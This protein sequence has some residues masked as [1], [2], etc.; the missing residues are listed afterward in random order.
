ME[1]GP[2]DI[3][4]D[5]FELAPTIDQLR[6]KFS[7]FHRLVL[8]VN[9]SLE[10]LSLQHGKARDYYVSHMPQNVR[11]LLNV[12]P[13]IPMPDTQSYVE[14]FD[15]LL[16]IS[17]AS[18]LSDDASRNSGLAAAKDKIA[19]LQMPIDIFVRVSV[20]LAIF[21][22]ILLCSSLAL[23]FFSNRGVRV[24]AHLFSY[25]VALMF[26]FLVLNMAIGGVIYSGCNQPNV[27][28]FFDQF[29]DDELAM[30]V[31]FQSL[32][33]PT[34]K[35]HELLRYWFETH[36]PIGADPVD[37]INGK[38][39]LY[40]SPEELIQITPNFTSQHSE[41]L[42][43][44]R[45]LLR[46]KDWS[47]QLDLSSITDFMQTH[48]AVYLGLLRMIKTPSGKS[49]E[50][51]TPDL[52]LKLDRLFAAVQHFA[53][54]ALPLPPD[55][56]RLDPALKETLTE[57]YFLVCVDCLAGVNN[58]CIGLLSTILLLM[59]FLASAKWLKRRL[60]HRSLI[61]DPKLDINHQASEF[62]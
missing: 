14:D 20:G 2:E 30:K 29:L 31:N 3:I 47:V 37:I 12:V 42:R 17:I 38:I 36:R 54:D 7:D 16:S 44:V 61:W 35:E 43:E 1:I 18:L 25:L 4:H 40:Y 57:I 23:I 51:E 33:D 50:Q 58:S 55:F 45:L 27:G 9:S 24:M 26:L 21:I 60:R 15:K 39:R 34:V 8:D 41:L 28:S 56:G 32:L 11:Q 52:F 48:R 49:L 5:N 59:L 6:H 10:K 46:L 22:C 62:I 53:D 13:H 19:M